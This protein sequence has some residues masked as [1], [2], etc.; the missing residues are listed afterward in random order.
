MPQSVAYVH[1]KYICS[2][3]VLLTYE[4][5]TYILIYYSVVGGDEQNQSMLVQ[6]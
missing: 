1:P 3:V 4:D 5:T 2:R 6:Y